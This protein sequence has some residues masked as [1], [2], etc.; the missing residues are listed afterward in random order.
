VTKKVPEASSPAGLRLRRQQRRLPEALKAGHTSIMHSSNHLP[1]PQEARIHESMALKRIERPHKDRSWAAP[2][3]RR[4]PSISDAMSFPEDSAIMTASSSGS[5]SRIS[6]HSSRRRRV[7][8]SLVHNPDHPSCPHTSSSICSCGSNMADPHSSVEQQCDRVIFREDSDSLVDS[9]D[10]SSRLSTNHSTKVPHSYQQKQHHSL[11]T[12]LKSLLLLV[13]V[14]LI[15]NFPAA[16][17]CSSRST[18]KP[19]PPSHSAIRPNITFQTYACPPAYAAWYCLNGATCFTVKIADSIL[20][21]CECADGYMGQRCEFK[22][23]DGTYLPA[24]ERLS[25]LWNPGSSLMHSDD[26]DPT[27]VTSTTTNVFAGCLLIVVAAA[28][29]CAVYTKSRSKAKRASISRA[30][31]SHLDCFNEAAASDGKWVLGHLAEKM[32]KALKKAAPSGG[33]KLE[34]NDVEQRATPSATCQCHD[35][36]SGNQY[37]SFHTTHPAFHHH[38]QLTDYHQVASNPTSTSSEPSAA[39]CSSQKRL[40]NQG[41]SSE[42]VFQIS[43]RLPFNVCHVTIR[44]PVDVLRTLDPLVPYPASHPPPSLDDVSTRNA[45]TCSG[46][47]SEEPSPHQLTPTSAPAEGPVQLC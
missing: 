35:T 46:S 16:D 31:E 45:S 21:N 20:Y 14:I 19:R 41:T 44:P 25:M 24:R 30:Q 18:P 37:L 27:G 4:T 6:L 11:T 42:A 29:G 13:L 10:S 3:D 39:G 15:V 12:V 34:L 1:H 5:S 7:R 8:D 47:T 22:D 9:S 40:Q 33:K 2:S 36:S 26:S 38:Q 23:L 28:V 32:A 43:S 17:G